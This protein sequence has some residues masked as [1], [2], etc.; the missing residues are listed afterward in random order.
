MTTVLLLIGL[1]AVVAA[2]AYVQASIGFGL[3][4]LLVPFA[5]LLMPHLVPLPALVVNGVVSGVVARND[6]HD[7]D[8][9]L[10]GVLAVTGLPGVARRSRR[11]APS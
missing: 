1:T 7:L 3:N 10:L 6:R 2:G 9:R 8:R 4:L 5:L 11:A